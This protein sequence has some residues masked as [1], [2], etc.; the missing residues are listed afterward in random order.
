[1]TQISVMDKVNYP[2]LSFGC[3]ALL[4]LRLHCAWGARAIFNLRTGEIDTPLGR[5]SIFG[6]DQDVALLKEWLNSTG[7]P[8]LALALEQEVRKH[9]G[10]YVN[11]LRPQAWVW[12]DRDY[13]GQDT[14]GIVFGT[15]NE[16][17]GYIYLAAF[18]HDHL[19]LSCD[20][21]GADRLLEMWYEIDRRRE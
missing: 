2:E 11:A 14:T 20:T 6:L 12:I 13:S 7:L 8:K 5:Q 16:S 1:M 15:C 21:Q 9:G 3:T 19:P 17:Y 4:P 10:E 18:L